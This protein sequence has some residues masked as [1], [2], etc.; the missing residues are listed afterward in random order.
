MHLMR[1]SILCHSQ[2]SWLITSIVRSVPPV[3]VLRCSSNS[4]THAYYAAV[5]MSQ[6]ALWL[7]T[8]TTLPVTILHCSSNISIAD[9]VCTSGATRT[10]HFTVS[11]SFM[12]WG[13]ALR[14]ACACRSATEALSETW[15]SAACCQPF[16]KISCHALHRPY[17][18]MQAAQIDERSDISLHDD[19]QQQWVWVLW[20]LLQPGQFLFVLHLQEKSDT[21][22]EGALS[23]LADTA[24]DSC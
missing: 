7:I 2:L 8:W 9:W 14:C 4:I 21:E 15:N 22:H 23:H 16:D 3:T 10:T 6:S 1:L 11:V 5:T 19:R 24:L 13:R 12:Q 18:C 20:V 17:A